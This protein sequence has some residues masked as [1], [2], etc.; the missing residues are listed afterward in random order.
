MDGLPT[1]SNLP[2]PRQRQAWQG[3]E[4]SARLMAGLH[5]GVLAGV[6]GDI[7]L[8]VESVRVGRPAWEAVNL[9]STAI[10]GRSGYTLRFGLA[11]V[12][13]LSLHMVMTGLFGVVF[14]IL[15]GP[16]TRPLFSAYAGLLFSFG[17]FVLNFGWILPRVAPIVSH[18]ASRFQ[19][20]GVHFLT[21]MILGLYP[22]FARGL[23]RKPLPPPALLPPATDPPT[24]DS[25]V[26]AAAL[27]AIDSPA[28]D[29]PTI[30]SPTID[31]PIQEPSYEPHS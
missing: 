1:V 10:L 18:N 19:W 3:G 20:A 21:G 31:P 29:P 22:E 26:T 16:R 4:W 13:G 24:I 9:V 30:G 5:A 8:V 7:W 14:A 25:S 2:G 15:L 12:A 17:C 11:S 27:P 23:L 28:I 6:L